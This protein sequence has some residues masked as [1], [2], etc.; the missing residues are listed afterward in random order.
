MK[1]KLVVDTSIGAQPYISIKT[2]LSGHGDG[3]RYEL[4][5]TKTDGTVLMPPVEIENPLDATSVAFVLSKAMA[6]VNTLSYGYNNA[7][8]LWEGN[9]WVSGDAWMKTLSHS[10]HGLMRTGEYSSKA[11]KCFYNT[12]RAAWLSSGRPSLE[13]K[14]FGKCLGVPLENSVLNVIPHEHIKKMPVSE[15]RQHPALWDFETES[16]KALDKDIFSGD[17]HQ[18]SNGSMHVLPVLVQAVIKEAIALA[19]DERNDSLLMSFLRS[20]LDPDQRITL[21]RWFGLHLVVHRVGN[22]QKML[23]MY[24][25][26]GNGKGVIVGLLRALLTDDAVAT[27]NLK[28]L[29]VSSNLEMLVGKLAM[30]GSEGK[31]ETD[32]ELLKTLVAWEIIN[33][34]PKYRDPFQLLPQ[35]LV[36]QAS[37]PPPHFDDDS[38]AMVRRVIALEMLHQPK[39]PIVGLVDRIKTDEYAL[40]VA[41]AMQGA[42]EVLRAGTIVVPDTVAS[43]SAQIVRPIRT[44]DRF[45]T[46][47]EPGNF[48][49]ADDELYAAYTLSS[50]R[51]GLAISP[52]AE[53]LDDLCVRLDRA[54]ITY[55][56]RA[57]AT[58]YLAQKHV[59]DQQKQVAL[60]PQLLEAKSAD[61]F[62][63]FRISEG[64]FGQAIGQVIPSNRREVP[65]FS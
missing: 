45:V 60:V 40:L 53:F 33:V 39:S 26:G 34:N 13:L 49:I 63:G 62:M 38:D 35:C 51:Q 61:L 20:S 14:A 8:Y 12:M 44:V 6:N 64:P 2:S 56:R 22:P 29:T 36:T 47:L 23:F 52:K 5:V 24:G 54:R 41:W 46:L 17:P 37:N 59:N 48:E 11:S 31:A 42:L 1:S 4:T 27:L 15:L 9:R 28:D 7:A 16:P 57:K 65:V 19:N 32:N 55:I 43:H 50:K 18:P 21:Q 25:P 10:M 30:I 3:R 58:G